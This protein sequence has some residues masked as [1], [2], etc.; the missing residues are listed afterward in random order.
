MIGT[1]QITSAA[2]KPFLWKSEPIVRFR[3]DEGKVYC[4]QHHTLSFVY[5]EETQALSVKVPDGTITLTGR[6]AWEVCEHLCAGKV[7]MIRNDGV[8]VTEVGFT[9]DED[10][11]V[12]L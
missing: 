2:V 5:N 8:Q 10:E 7:T 9:P 4:A 12:E 3:T 1:P 6:G 11:S